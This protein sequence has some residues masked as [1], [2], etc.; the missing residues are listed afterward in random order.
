LVFY[1]E[2]HWAEWWVEKMV[3]RM[4]E[5]MGVDLVESKVVWSVTKMADL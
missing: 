1:W 2:T 3:S 4:A 5:M